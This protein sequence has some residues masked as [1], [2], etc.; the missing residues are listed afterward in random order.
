MSEPAK[1]TTKTG[2]TSQPQPQ[3]QPAKTSDLKNTQELKKTLSL[4]S[5]QLAEQ[6]IR[7]KKV[8]WEHF[9]DYK[10]N[11]HERLSTF[12]PDERDQLHSGG[13]RETKRM[14]KALQLDQP[15]SKGMHV[16][17]LCCGEG[18]TAVYLG[19]HYGFQVTGL[20]IVDKAVETAKQKAEAEKVG[21]KIHFICGTAFELPFPPNTFNHIYGQDPDAFSHPQRIVIF[22]EC[23]RVLKPG[24][25]LYLHHHWIPGFEFPLEELKTLEAFNLALGWKAIE[26]CSATT[27]VR[28]CKASG[29][30]IL[31]ADDLTDLASSHLRG[32]ALKHMKAT[33][34]INDKWLEN[35]LSYIDRGFHFG[36]RIVA[37]K[38][39]G[40]KKEDDCVVS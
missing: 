9:E 27:Y 25:L 22:K 2:T 5:Q 17:D 40:K 35:V 18:A 10:D 7:E 1:E 6:A 11:F 26:D 12:W 36:V 37:R 13:V 33:G 34:A 28:D 29:F 23:L 8:G 30:E 16:L 4:T 20:E 14:V 38:P 31:K 19:K 3:E 24:G 15:V 32:V 21:D 39:G